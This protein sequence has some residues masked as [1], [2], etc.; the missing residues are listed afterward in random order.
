MEEGGD[1]PPGA[2]LVRLEGGVRG[3]GGDLLLHRP[4]H[5]A[6]IGRVLGHIV[7]GARRGILPAKGRPD[8]VHGLGPGALRLRVKALGDHTP[9]R[10]PAHRLGVKLFA[11][12]GDEAPALA[13]RLPLR[14]PQ[15]GDDLGVGAVVLRGEGI[16][17]GS[18]GNPG[19]HRPGYRLGVIGVRLHVGK[20]RIRRRL[21]GRVIAVVLA[22]QRQPAV[23]KQVLLVLGVG[24]DRAAAVDR[25]VALPAAALPRPGQEELVRRARRALVAVGQVHQVIFP[26]L[27][28]HHV[29]H[30]AAAVHLAGHGVAPHVPAEPGQVAQVLER[31]GVPLAHHV[32]GGVAVEHV[33][34][35]PGVAVGRAAPR[36]R[37]VVRHQRADLP[38]VG[39]QL[40]MV[41]QVLIAL[42]NSL[43]GFRRLSPPGGLLGVHRG[44]AAP[45]VVR[46]RLDLDD[47]IADGR[48]PVLN[49]PVVFP[50]VLKPPPVQL[51]G[52]VRRQGRIHP[53]HVQ[54]LA[55]F[56]VQLAQRGLPVLLRQPQL[57][58]TPGQGAQ[59]GYLNDGAAPGPGGDFSRLLPQDLVYLPVRAGQAAARPARRLRRQR[60]ALEQSHR[61]RQ[62]QQRGKQLFFHLELPFHRPFPARRGFFIVPDPRGNYKGV[63]GKAGP[64]RR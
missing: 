38:A 1:L 35:L 52:A 43:S 27:H 49:G 59:V 25:R 5:R 42:H 10:R 61:Q 8:V 2:H 26:V 31:L 20:G 34:Q 50:A 41:G 28:A 18:L 37:L 14:P 56:L 46:G 58:Q 64:F 51:I 16:R 3:P 23:H 39:V 13:V 48:P 33:H 44:V 32:G 45:L 7:K 22:A 47:Q 54:V 40:L 21:G 17:A 4:G 36:R 19:L 53:V 6:G 62:R 55:E 12:E 63:S 60:P 15:K 30:V 29:P 24:V 9:L 57:R 11:A